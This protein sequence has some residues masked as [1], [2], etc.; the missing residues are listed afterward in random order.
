MLD[1]FGAACVLKSPAT[2]INSPPVIRM[3][4][5]LLNID[6]KMSGGWKREM[7]V[8]YGTPGFACSLRNIYSLNEEVNSGRLQSGG[9]PQ[10]CL[11]IGVTRRRKTAWS[12]RNF[13]QRRPAKGGAQLLCVF[14]TVE[15]ILH[16][17]PVE[18]AVSYTAYLDLGKTH[19]MLARR[20]T[21]RQDGM[22]KGNGAGTW[23]I[24]APSGRY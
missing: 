19:E 4:E 5:L 8:T 17:R 6:G 20:L 12:D 9:A 21:G 14:S 1:P 7:L 22:A 2:L 3:W 16:R 13:Q 18:E 23:N 11:G 24:R 10:K 15:S